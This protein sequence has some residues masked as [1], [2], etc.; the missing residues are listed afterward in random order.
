MNFLDILNL[1][2]ESVATLSLIVIYRLPS[3][4]ASY[5]RKMKSFE[6]HFLKIANYKIYHIFSS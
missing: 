5:L 3:D 6:T 4:T 1:K 2:E